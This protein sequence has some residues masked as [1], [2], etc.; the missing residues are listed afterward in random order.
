[1][2]DVEPVTFTI[3]FFKKGKKYGDEYKAICTVQKIGCVAYVSGLHGEISRRDYE[4][5]S[6][7]MSELGCTEL[8][9]LK[10]GQEKTYQN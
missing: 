8:R 4:E 9:W 10:N 1:M 2:V 7:K 6:D 3:R 5:F